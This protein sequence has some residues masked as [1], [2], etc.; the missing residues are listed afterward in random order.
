VIDFE[1]LGYSALV[2]LLLRI[3]TTKSFGRFCRKTGITDGALRGA[4]EEI[5]RG[6]IDADLGGGVLKKRIARAGGGKSGG[7]RTLLAFRAGDRTVFIF[8]FAK[9]DLDNISSSQLSSLKEA[10]EVYLG[11]TDDEIDE[12]LRAGAL[13]EIAYA[14]EE[15]DEEE[16]DGAERE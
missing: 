8:G 2:G 3:F 13:G 16:A 1:L 12:A 11:L 9:S 5:E 14:E 10:A 4:V 7:F 6:L 15:N